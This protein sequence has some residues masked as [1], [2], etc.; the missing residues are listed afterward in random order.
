MKEAGFPAFQLSV[1]VADPAEEVVQPVEPRAVD[2]QTSRRI[3]S[4]GRRIPSTGRAISFFMW[5]FL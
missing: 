2:L 5:L 3:P 4:T 1:A